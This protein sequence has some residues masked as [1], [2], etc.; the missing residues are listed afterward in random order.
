KVT[1]ITR[2]VDTPYS[3]MLPGHIAG[4]YT[5]EECHIDLR[6]MARFAGV[7]LVHT[8]AVGLDTA[9]C[10]VH[11]KDGRPPIRYDVLSI[12]IGSTPKF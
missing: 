11:C 6:N 10:L 7:G 9:K 8:E 12:N 1:L 3:G 4:H 2:D 5:R